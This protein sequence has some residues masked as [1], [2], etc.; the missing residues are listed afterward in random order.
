MAM[1]FLAIIPIVLQIIL[2]SMHFK[3]AIL[4][5]VVMA[6]TFVVEVTL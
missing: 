6:T 5:F 2:A 1:N 3:V 4:P